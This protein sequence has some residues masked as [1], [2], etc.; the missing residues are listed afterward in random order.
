MSTLDQSFS[1]SN[2][3]IIF[4]LLNRR[5]KID[6]K[7]LSDGYQKAIADIKEI[8]G[9]ISEIRKKKK[10]KWTDDDKK[11]LKYWNLEL[12]RLYKE[13][14]EQLDLNMEEIAEKVNSSHFRMMMTHHTYGGHDEFTLDTSSLYTQFAIAQLL[15][16]LKRAFNVRMYDRHTIM[17]ALKS[18]LNSKMPL[19][20][21]RTDAS[22]FFES[23][24]QD[25][26]MSKIEG[27]TL[28]SYKSLAF[29]KGILKEFERIKTEKGITDIP[30]GNGVP[31]GVGISSMLSEIYMQDIDR[32]LRN[33]KETMFY[34]RYVDDIILVVRSIG[35]CKD[36]EDYYNNLCKF[37]SNN[38]LT[39]KPVG[40]AKCQLSDLVNFHERHNFDYLGYKIFIDP[41]SAN[42]NVRYDLSS[43]KAQK[44]RNRID[45][46]FFAF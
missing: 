37:F 30:N 24:P 35:Q 7:K 1:A 22:K 14:K 39:L 41:I 17:S 29:I 9:N 26:L 44:I 21:I 27:S 20:L 40:D 5:G 23:I 6:V 12:E 31:R 38:G 28:L 3:H 46:V 18:L 34:V 4:N 10:S 32:K 33:R 36:I 15:H 45:N 13:K 43:N 42:D 11:N 16:N 2:F 19:F 25:K 8:R